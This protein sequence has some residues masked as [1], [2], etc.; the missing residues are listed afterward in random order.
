MSDEA[1]SGYTSTAQETSES[2]SEEIPSSNSS[3]AGTR[4]YSSD[5]EL[6]DGGKQG[7]SWQGVDPW[8][9]SCFIFQL[10]SRKCAPGIR[11]SAEQRRHVSGWGYEMVRKAGLR[12]FLKSDLL[13]VVRTPVL[14]RRCNRHM[15][16][17]VRLPLP[18]SLW[19]WLLSL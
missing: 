19:R 5:S 17:D 6:E 3:S 14:Y 7:P 16:F 4:F 12:A 2:D 11:L 8:H 15:V 9:F 13:I 10:R 18:Y 1:S